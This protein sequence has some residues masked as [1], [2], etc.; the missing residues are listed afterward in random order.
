MLSKAMVLF[1]IVTL[2]VISLEKT[3]EIDK[4]ETMLNNKNQEIY[5]LQEKVS[6]LDESYQMAA[7]SSFNCQVA[8]MK[9][10]G[11]IK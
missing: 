10:T 4:L 6:S 2:A 9:A 8:L 3:K 7:D 5:R 1:G 11:Q